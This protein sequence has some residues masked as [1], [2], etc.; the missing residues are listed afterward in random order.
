MSTTG[1][2]LAGGA[3]RR[4]DGRDK[5]L[6]EWRGRPLAAHVAASLSPQVDQLLISCNR[7]FERY[8]DIAAITIAD[9]RRD[10]QG[11]LAGIEAA[12]PH[13]KGNYLAISACDTP[14]LPGDLV[15]R[16]LQALLNASDGQCD[17]AFAHDGEQAQYLCAVLRTSCLDT[18]PA[19]LDSGQ[20]AV[21]HWYHSHR[22]LS[23]DFSDEAARFRNLNYK[24][25]M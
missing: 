5:G 24:L 3:G 19:Y 13:I 1:L 20:R 16:L 8:A 22:H 14:E 15:Q 10:F 2:I 18:L 21:R 11:P 7:N 17:I 4:V 25:D 9:S 12:T 6:I 23:V